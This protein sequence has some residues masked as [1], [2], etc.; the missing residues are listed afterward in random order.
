MNHAPA[1]TTAQDRRRQLPVRRATAFALL[2]AALLLCSAWAS[3]A[4]ADGT[5]LDITSDKAQ[6]S[7]TYPDP[8]TGKLT[9]TNSGG[10]LSVDSSKLSQS[11]QSVL[12]TLALLGLVPWGS[13]LDQ[14]WS[15]SPGP[16]GQTLMDEACHLAQQQITQ[17]ASSGSYRA[18]GA[19]CAFTPTGG[20]VYGEIETQWGVYDPR[21]LQDTTVTGQRLTISYV[22]PHN[23]ITFNVSTPYTSGS[24][25]PQFTATFDLGVSLQFVTSDG[26]CAL[27]PSAYGS[28]QDLSVNPNNLA[29]NIA[30]SFP[31][32]QSYM[33][34]VTSVVNGEVFDGA[35]LLKQSGSAGSG[36]GPF[37]Q[38]WSTACHLG[39]STVSAS[40][41][42]AKGL[43][44]EFQDTSPWFPPGPVGSLFDATI[45]PTSSRQVRSGGQIAI[46]GT[47]F[48]YSASGQDSNTVQF[49]LDSDPTATIGQ[50]TIGQSGTFS[51]NV[52]IPKDASAGQHTLT[53]Q[54]AAPS[55]QQATTTISV[56]G[57]GQAAQPELAFVD[58]NTGALTPSTRSLEG[59]PITLHGASF[60]AGQT[61]A[62][63]LD[64]DGGQVVGTATAGSDGSFQATFT[65]PDPQSGGLGNHKLVAVARGGNGKKVQ[66]TATLD[67]ETAQ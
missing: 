13:A 40:L 1:E 56:L 54:V 53:A 16:N 28:I 2:L 52:T 11:D 66:A 43:L 14:A 4:R 5:N 48:T 61:V 19:D 20:T 47:Y 26:P 10:L 34:T 57:G 17:Q 18:Y 67:I 58:P 12:G 59:N 37:S 23:S 49:S 62:V 63:Y 44:L 30:M 64:S 6:I 7:W 29:A 32:V 39:F 21:T 65:T 15:Q 46:S 60:P 25:D 42:N 31:E 36:F 3:S 41:D 50:A 55:T 35:S 33:A 27:T 24:T 38:M 22:V 51:A 9:T 45:Q 8:T